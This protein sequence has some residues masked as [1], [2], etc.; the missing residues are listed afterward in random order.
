ML[1]YSLAAAFDLATSALS[2]STN[3]VKLVY[4]DQCMKAEC[5]IKNL[6]IYT[7]IVILK[8]AIDVNHH[9]SKTY[10]YIQIWYV[11]NFTIK[12]IQYAKSYGGW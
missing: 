4:F 10:F 3:C 9:L 6:P 7:T 1:T 5:N 2:W 8:A 11:I 12:Y